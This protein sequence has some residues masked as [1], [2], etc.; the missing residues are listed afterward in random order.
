MMLLVNFSHAFP[1]SV[2]QRRIDD[3]IRHLCDEVSS[4]THSDS[5][6]AMQELSV[7]L[8]LKFER[9]KVRAAR[10]FLSGEHVEGERRK[11]FKL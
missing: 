9:L 10:I 4:A 1:M 5:Q 7:L 6:S 8:R 3:R 11:P 2:P